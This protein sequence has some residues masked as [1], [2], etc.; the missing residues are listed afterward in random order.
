MTV[1]DLFSRKVRALKLSLLD[2]LPEDA[3]QSNCISSKLANAFSE[4]LNSHLFLV[5]IEAESRLVVDVGPLGDVQVGGSRG[6]EFLLN[7]VGRV[8]QVLKQVGRD[9][10]I[11]ATGKL[12]DFTNVSE[13]G[14]HDDCL[15]S[16]LLVVVEDA[17]HT[18]DTRVFRGGEVLLH[19]SLVPIEDTADE[20][21]DEEGTGLGG[22]D[23]LDKG[24]HEGQVAVDTLLLQDLGGLDPFPSRSYLDQDTGLIDANGL[25]ELQL[26]RFWV[27]E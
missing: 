15:V 4:L 8:V 16:V 22:G 24:E 21:G 26:V 6:I 18:L 3:L 7:L 2:L 11:V 19:G 9:G 1:N 12:G 14:A 5:E 23:G 25:V 17:L 27:S 10:K 20:G 13:R